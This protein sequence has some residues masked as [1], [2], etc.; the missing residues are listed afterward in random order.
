MCSASS[1]QYGDQ[2]TEACV[3]NAALPKTES[4]KATQSDTATNV[5]VQHQQNQ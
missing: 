5:D 2:R 4:F 3:L 1:K